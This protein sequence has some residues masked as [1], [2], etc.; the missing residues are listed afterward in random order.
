MDEPLYSSCKSW[1]YYLPGLLAISLIYWTG[2]IR[3]FIF[4]EFIYLLAAT[5]HRRF[6]HYILFKD[7][8]V[9]KRGFFRP[10]FLELKL[11]QIKDVK[12]RQGTFGFLCDYGHVEFYGLAGE[13]ILFKGI[14]DPEELGRK[15]MD[16][17][18]G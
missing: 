17:K 1:N 2:E 8:V 13:S 12:I 4:C 3:F 16:L 11:D 5:F 14:K 10:A 15:V 9:L 7:R 6:T 18:K